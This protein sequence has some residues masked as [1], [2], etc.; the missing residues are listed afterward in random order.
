MTLDQLIQQ[1]AAQISYSKDEKNS[2]AKSSNHI[3]GLIENKPQFYGSYLG[4]S[5]KRSTMVKQVSDVDVYIQYM[6]GF[7]PKTVLKN[8]KTYLEVSY[9]NSEIRQ[10]KP[11]ILV[12]FNKIP[13]NIT[14]YIQDNSGIIKI[15]NSSLD[16]WDM[17][18]FGVLEQRIIDLR[19]KDSKLIDLIKILKYWNFKYKKELQNYR[20]EEIVC[21]QFGNSFLDDG[22][23]NNLLSFFKMN[24]YAREAEK[25]HHLINC[26]TFLEL[27]E[28]KK[29]WLDF[30]DKR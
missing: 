19:S 27:A 2:I 23:A 16:Y 15:P 1:K 18:N 9:P 6:G 12:N 29:S 8:L 4:G 11:S 13:F 17:I 24:G 21:S 5:Y 10:D 25:I 3:R 30:I 14:P 20:I 28:L 7:M 22:I 26:Y